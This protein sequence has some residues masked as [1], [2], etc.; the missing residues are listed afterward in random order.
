MIPDE[1]IGKTVVI[2]WT[3]PDH[4]WHHFRVL[5][6][7]NGWVKLQGLS[8]TEEEEEVPYGGLPFWTKT[9]T[10]DTLEE[11]GKGMKDLRYIGMTD[12]DTPLDGIVQ[13]VKDNGG[14]LSILNMT[15]TELGPAVVIIALSS[16][17]DMVLGALIGAGIPTETIVTSLGLDGPKKVKA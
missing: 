1:L 10:I 12:K 6:Q 5:A 11:K 2:E 7:Q 14:N 15:T 13:K 16:N 4:D 8:E 17:V 9:E 3:N